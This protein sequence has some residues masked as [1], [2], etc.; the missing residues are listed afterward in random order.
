VSRRRASRRA[1]R[2]AT[3]QETQERAGARTAKGPPDLEAEGLDDDQLTAA[4]SEAVEAL[5]EGEA[6]ESYRDRARSAEA[7]LAKAI[8]AYRQLKDDNDE[9]RQRMARNIQR[10]YDEKRER[11]LLKFIEILDNLDR[12]LEAA[13][14]SYVTEPLIEGLILVRTQLLQTLQAEG[15]ERVPV[16]GL[17]YDPSIAEAVQTEEVEEP[18]RHHVVLKELLRSY[19][20]DGRVI[21]AGHVVVGQHPN[22]P[23]AP[24]AQE[25]EPD[26]E[27]WQEDPE[28][29]ASVEEIIARSRAQQSLLPGQGEGAAEDEPDEDE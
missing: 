29:E 3:T 17:A 12:A 20:F 4:L 23:A 27:T 21:R 16:L 2:R 1:A 7:Q 25:P 22:P 28:L 15:L 9:F 13:E 24:P 6:T 14:R 11:L 19:R 10:G 26:A 5:P 18:E 8:A